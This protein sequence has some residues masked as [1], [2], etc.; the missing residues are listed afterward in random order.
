[1]ISLRSVPICTSL[2]E[3]ATQGRV[4]ITPYSSIV[5]LFH[6]FSRTANQVVAVHGSIPRII[7]SGLY[8]KNGE[9]VEELE[10]LVDLLW[11]I[12]ILYPYFITTIL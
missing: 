4:V 10:F 8:G 5:T 7:M 9:R 12:V 2:S 6:S 3:N 1:M 11:I